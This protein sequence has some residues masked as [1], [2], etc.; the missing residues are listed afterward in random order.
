[1]KNAE[2]DAQIT[3][4]CILSAAWF[5]QEHL[6]ARRQTITRNPDDIPLFRGPSNVIRV[7]THGDL[8]ILVPITAR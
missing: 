4:R 2:I 1:M 3:N 6:L 7:M 8:R 5:Y